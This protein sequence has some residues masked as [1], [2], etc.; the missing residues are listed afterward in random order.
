MRFPTL[1]L[2]HLTVAAAFSFGFAMLIRFTDIC[3]LQAVT[4]NGKY[5]AEWQTEF[6]VSKGTTLLDNPADDIAKRLLNHTGVVRVDISYGFPDELHVRTND[7]N[8]RSFV[9]DNT[10]GTLRGLTSD[11]RVVGLNGGN[12][13]WENPVFTGIA[14]APVLGYCSDPR[15]PRVME[16]LDRL[17]ESQYELYRL[18]DELS[19]RHADHL[20]LTLAGVP[21]H[22]RVRADKLFERMNEFI[23]FIEQFNPDTEN[24][25]LFDLR[26]DEMIVRVG[27]EG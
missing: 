21:Y 23:R 20:R 18:V 26:F 4:V 22:I 27:S 25:T 10:T 13:D 5:I 19:F 14:N 11:C 3:E 2:S 6:A 8:V 9:L 7:F 17:R 24:A 15:V 16:Q 12:V 1:R